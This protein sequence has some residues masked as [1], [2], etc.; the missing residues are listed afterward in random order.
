M[1]VHIIIDGYNLI[2]ASSS[3][4]RAEAVS[5]EEGRRTLLERVAAYKRVKHWP[6]TVVYDGGGG[7][8]LSPTSEREKGIQVVYSPAGQTADQ[9]I[10]GMA[11]RK[12]ERAL[13]VTS[14]RALAETVEAAGATALSSPEFEERME[15]AFYL[16]TKG[17]VAEEE[18]I[19][20]TLSTK[21]KGP[22][23]RRPK[24][25]RRKAARVSK[26]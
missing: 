16:E 4:S 18:D 2:R 13:V 11:R 25:D 23:K 19:E 1:G 7:G 6:V 26:I 5:L 24:A 17:P 3:L 12:G 21:K 22:P 20:P 8:R 15:L 10:A 14:D 9:V